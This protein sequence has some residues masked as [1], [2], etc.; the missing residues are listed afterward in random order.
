[1]QKVRFN[2]IYGACA[3]LTLLTAT[4][5]HA[6]GQTPE[7]AAAYAKGTSMPPMAYPGAPGA[8]MTGMTPVAQIQQGG[9][10]Q[11]LAYTASTAAIQNSV[12]PLPGQTVGQKLPNLPNAPAP[13]TPSGVALND[14][15]PAT[16][17]EDVRELKRRMDGV[18]RAQMEAPGKRANPVTRSITLRQSPGETPAVVR[19]TPGVPTNILFIDNTGQPWPIDYIIPGDPAKFEMLMAVPGTPS[20]QIRPKV[21]YGYGGVSVILRDNHIPIPLSLT[22]SQDEV[23]SRLDVKVAR[24]GPYA[25]APIIDNTGL[26][27]AND[28][29]LMNFIEGVPPDSAKEVKTSSKAVRAWRWNGKLVVRSDVPVVS[30]GWSDSSQSAGGTTNAYV[31]PNVPELIVTS[32]GRLAAVQ[33]EE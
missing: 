19:L 1:M 30:P 20:M 28:V 23:D 7:Q 33:I 9:P 8:A 12:P 32:Q 25:A 17:A 6:I 2:V 10:V 22:V 3:V 26:P 15:M 4:S 16:L 5:A 13:V 18:Q 27:G 29:S 11:P 24:K 21:D 31:L 14:T